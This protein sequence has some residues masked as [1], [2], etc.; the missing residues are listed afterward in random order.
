[1]IAFESAIIETIARLLGYSVGAAAAIGLVG[2]LVWIVVRNLAENSAHQ[3]PPPQ[4][5]PHV[6]DAVTAAVSKAAFDSFLRSQPQTP[7]AAK[8]PVDESVSP[9]D[10]VTELRSDA[11]V[12]LL[13]PEARAELLRVLEAPEGY[14][15]Q[16]ASLLARSDKPG[17][18]NV[19]TLI[20]TANTDEVARLGMLRALRNTV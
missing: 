9:A 6:D 7:D 1:M 12:W 5:K 13:P 20:E 17:Y 3:A 15:R 11:S 2:S 16:M 4:P 18:A 10:E 19:A 14:R 8:D